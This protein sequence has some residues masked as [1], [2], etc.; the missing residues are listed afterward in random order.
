MRPNRSFGGVRC[1]MS[2]SSQKEQKLARKVVGEYGKETGFYGFATE[3]SWKVDA[4]EAGLKVRR[5]DTTAN[6]EQDPSSQQ[7]I[8][9]CGDGNRR[10]P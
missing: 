7:D 2:F 9:L 1:I 8:P 5:D 4:R 6:A 3:R 10:N